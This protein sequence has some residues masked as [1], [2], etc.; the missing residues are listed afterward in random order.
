[1]SNETPWRALPPLAAAPSA[2]TAAF[3]A[4]LEAI[5]A[6]LPSP[7]EV[8]VQLVRE[9]RA[10]GEGVLPIDGPLPEARWEPVPGG[11]PVRVI[12]A[13]APRAVYLHIH[14][15][16]WTFGG[17]DQSD[18]RCLRLSRAASVDTVSVS[19]RFGPEDPWPACAD[20]CFA[21]ARLALAHADA[22]GG[23]P[24][25]IGGESAGGHLTAVTLLRLREA[26]L[27][28]GVAGAVLNY[29]CFDLR[30]TP[31]MRL[32]G[33]RVLVLSTPIVDWFIGNLLGED[34][35]AAETPLASPLLADLSGMPPALVQ[36][37]DLD[38]LL[39]DSLLMA[40]RWRAAG[41]E[42]DLAVWPGGVHG[43]DM[44]DKP[45]HG[46]PIALEAQAAVADWITAQLDRR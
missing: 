13:E 23:L 19:Y 27:I 3:N 36:I 22:K 11:R 46:L 26:G 1:M 37:G 29:G 15:G 24:L 21:A 5:M 16:G 14:G 20:D 12:E 33:G 18:G 43:F 42:A 40:E 17:P 30:M 4:K 35:A 38:P 41:A 2:E 39:D 7:W 44:F 34:R 8:P 32:W 31:S 6:T 25:F 45:A 10:R 28:D 9:L